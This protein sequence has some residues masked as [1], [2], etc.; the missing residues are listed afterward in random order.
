LPTRKS[1]NSNQ[2]IKSRNR[3][4]EIEEEAEDEV[5]DL[6]KVWLRKRPR[7]RELKRELKREPMIRRESWSKIT[8]RRQITKELVAT[9]GHAVAT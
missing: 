2:G 5:E 6:V 4:I 7:R 1:K 3:I 8:P 9:A